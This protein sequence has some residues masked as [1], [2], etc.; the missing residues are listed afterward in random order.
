MGI[1]RVVRP[2]WNLNKNAQQWLLTV[3][4][5]TVLMVMSFASLKPVSTQTVHL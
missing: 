1:R 5:S 3:N 2:V 4:A